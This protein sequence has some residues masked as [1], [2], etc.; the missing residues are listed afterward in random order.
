MHAYLND[1]SPGCITRIHLEAPLSSHPP[2]GSAQGPLLWLSV[3]PCLD[4]GS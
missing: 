4:L 3:G 1:P 2:A